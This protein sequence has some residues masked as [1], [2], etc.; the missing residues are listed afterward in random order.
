MQMQTPFA[1]AIRRATNVRSFLASPGARAFDSLLHDIPVGHFQFHLNRWA[2]C[3][4]RRLGNPVDQANSR[5]S[6]NKPSPGLRRQFGRRLLDAGRASEER[7]WP[8]WL[9]TALLPVHPDCRLCGAADF[10]RCRQVFTSMIKIHQV[11]RLR[12]EL[13]F[14]LLAQPRRAI[15]YCVNPRTCRKPGRLRHLPQH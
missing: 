5:D 10:R 6:D 14:H 2:G 1:S 15:P 7:P 8:D 12:P 11:S 9:L 13:A 4:P 3:W